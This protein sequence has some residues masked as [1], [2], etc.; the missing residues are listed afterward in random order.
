M[1]V[2]TTTVDKRDNLRRQISFRTRGGIHSVLKNPNE[3]SI[4]IK[5]QN[6]FKPARYNRDN[7]ED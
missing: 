7:S 5:M 6:V 2:L 1:R 4:G 3:N